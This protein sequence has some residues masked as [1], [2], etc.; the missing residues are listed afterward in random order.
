MS[1][2]RCTGRS[3]LLEALGSL[4]WGPSGGVPRAACSTRETGRQTWWD[5]PP[6]SPHCP[7][8]SPAVRRD[9]GCVQPQEGQVLCEMASATQVGEPRLSQPGLARL[10]SHLPPRSGLGAGVRG[11]QY[12]PD[13]QAVGMVGGHSSQPGQ[14]T[15]RPSTPSGSPGPLPRDTQTTPPP[16]PRR[17]PG[18]STSAAPSPRPGCC[19]GVSTQSARDEN[20]SLCKHKTDTLLLTPD[21]TRSFRGHQA[22]IAGSPETALKSACSPRGVF[23]VTPDCEHLSDVFTVV[24]PPKARGTRALGRWQPHPTP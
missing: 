19:Q 14:Q 1:P 12:S 17:V 16:P 21:G 24:F 7:P 8:N 18:A 20:V 9:S 15:S 3:R 23:A 4:G 13:H 22:G 10:P 11:R 5:Q 2:C 6:C